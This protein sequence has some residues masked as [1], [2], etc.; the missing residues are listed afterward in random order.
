MSSPDTWD[1]TQQPCS[2][3]VRPTVPPAKRF[4]LDNTLEGIDRMRR[5]GTCRT[6]TMRENISQ[7]YTFPPTAQRQPSF[8][9]VVTTIHVLL[10]FLT[11]RLGRIPGSEN[12]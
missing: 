3:E 2:C 10:S 7:A 5:L 4:V 6:E 9:Y 11:P 12:V 1:N 8:M